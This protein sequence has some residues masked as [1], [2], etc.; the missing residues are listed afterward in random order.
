MA[1]A[2]AH[3]RKFRMGEVEWN[4]DLQVPRN[5]ILAWK[6]K[7]SQLSGCRVSL[8]Y[9]IRCIKDADLPSGAFETTLPAAKLASKANFTE[10]KAAKKEHIV[11][12]ESWLSQLAQS[13][14]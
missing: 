3:F 14:A 4:P 1:Y 6:L 7:I 5:R 13:K 11:S 12:R 10:Y 2:T 9:H 8:R